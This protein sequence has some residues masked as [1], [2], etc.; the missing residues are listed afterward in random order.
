MVWKTDHYSG[1]GR[2]LRASGELGRPE[3]L[4]ALMTLLKDGP[5]PAIGNRRS[6]GDAALNSDGRAIDMTR[7][8]RILGFD[9]ETGVLH[10]EAG[11]TIGEMA[12]ISAEGASVTFLA[13]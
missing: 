8:N 3:R 12:Q 1:W 10:V 6:Y 9:A 2:A 4:S 7:M 11:M 13:L 5:I